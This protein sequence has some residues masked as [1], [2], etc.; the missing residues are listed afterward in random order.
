MIDLSKKT[1]S[2]VGSVFFGV[3]LNFLGD[4]S[5]KILEKAIKSLA[6]MINHQE[7]HSFHSIKKV[8]EF[9]NRPN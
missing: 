6:I 4:K 8:M 5:S 9:Y 2:E 7:D 3:L 1:V